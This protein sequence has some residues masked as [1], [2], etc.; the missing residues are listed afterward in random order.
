MRTHN[1]Q[2]NLI[3][4]A[5]SLFALLITVVACSES[6]DPQP[7]PSP[8]KPSVELVQDTVAQKK[9]SLDKLRN[10]NAGRVVTGDAYNIQET[11]VS[12]PVKVNVN[13]EVLASS[14]F[15]LLISAYKG[16]E[17]I[18]G[19]AY[20]SHCTEYYG[21]AAMFDD[22]NIAI[23]YVTQLDPSQ[24]YYYRAYF[25]FNDKE[26]GYGDTYEFTTPAPKKFTANAIDLGLSV[27]W[28]EANLGAT[29]GYQYGLFYPYGVTARSEKDQKAATPATTD[30]AGTDLDPATVELGDGWQMPTSAHIRE[31]LANTTYKVEDNYGVMGLRFYGKGDYAYSSI[32][33]PF[34]GNYNDNDTHVSDGVGYILWAGD[35]YAAGANRAASFK[36]TSKESEPILTNTSIYWR[37]PIRPVKV[38][39]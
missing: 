21:D 32:F 12:I 39:R 36:M 26:T 15:V 30:V 28:A 38:K 7:N 23:F 9:A 19:K 2:T 4:L 10:N 6:D 5:F 14:H 17:L 16:S 37:L 22:D 13:K 33:I 3:T 20:E 34:A 18:F 31:L 29:K 24:T 1:S 11:T 25:Y 27:K 35:R 8:D